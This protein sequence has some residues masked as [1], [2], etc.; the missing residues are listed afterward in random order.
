[1]AS[2]WAGTRAATPAPAD[3]VALRCPTIR[4]FPCIG[5]GGNRILHDVRGDRGVKR[6]D[7]D[8]LAQP[9]VAWR[10]RSSPPGD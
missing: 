9:G 2:H 4:M 5:T 3:G 6:F 8:V 1:M 7:R 10:R